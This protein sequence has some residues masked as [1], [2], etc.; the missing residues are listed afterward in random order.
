MS[1]SCLGL[2]TI[3]LAVSTAC[4]TA[5]RDAGDF[6]IAL[7][8]ARRGQ[9]GIFTMNADT[10]GGKLLTPDPGAQ[11]R[12]RSW[13]P[14]GK[15]IAF[16]TTRS[17]DAAILEH[18]RMPFHYLLYTVSSSGGSGTR[19]LDVPIS[20]FE[21]SPDSA[22]ILFI[23]SYEDPQHSDP[24]VLRGKK[25][26][27]SALYLLNLKTGKHRRLTSFGKNTSGS[28][29]PDAKRMAI[30]FGTDE[31]SD[32]YIATVDGRSTRRL[33]DSKAIYTKPAWSPDGRYIAYITVATQTSENQ[34]SGVYVMDAS[35]AGK[36]RLSAMSASSALWSPD[37]KQLLLQSAAGIALADLNGGK[38]LNPVPHVARPLDAQFTPDGDSITFRSNHEGEWHLY[39]VELTGK[40]L[41]RLT[42]KLSA[43]TYC[44]SPLRS[45]L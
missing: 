14:N 35:G 44:L 39:S 7:T 1:R 5:R 8:P 16:F 18:Y 20:S 4:S 40:N 30:S 3:L 9:Y 43:A 13:S 2:A 28:W 36:K 32:V 11:L 27:M 17:K 34:D 15:S 38:T 19:L 42:G 25:I 41:K 29:A 22:W 10:T 45:K 23:S 31:A 6:K 26:P 12:L 37:G 21:W 33:T 24:E